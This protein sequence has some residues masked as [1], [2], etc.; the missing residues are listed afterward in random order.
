MKDIAETVDGYPDG[1]NESDPTRR[2]QLIGEVWAEEG[3]LIDPPLAANGRT[4]ISDMAATLQAQFP[5]HRFERTSAV[6]EH[7]HHFRFSWQLVAADG[8]VTLNGMD[9]G[10]LA[11]DGIIARI[12]GFFGPLSSTEAA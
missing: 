8:S 2:A 3:K 10:E 9:V 5:D 6:D 11:D 4:E 7:H 12:T 1:W